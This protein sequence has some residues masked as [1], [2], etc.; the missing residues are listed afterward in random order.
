MIQSPAW[1]DILTVRRRVLL[2]LF[3]VFPLAGQQAIMKGR[4]T[5]RSG[6]AVADL[7]VTVTNQAT[8]VEHEIFTGPDGSWSLQLAPGLYAVGI[9]K[10]GQGA[11]AVQDVELDANST[12]TV[13]LRFTRAAENRNLRY[14]FYGFAAAWIVLAIYVIS[15][16]ARE[17]ALNR[18]L[19]GL[20]RMIESEKRV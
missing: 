15:L 2:A 3:F 6:A 20:R 12:H 4:V 18:Q 19:D 5:D 7:K 16:A 14:M 11:F 17:R 10:S 13:N 9:E 1:R 8:R